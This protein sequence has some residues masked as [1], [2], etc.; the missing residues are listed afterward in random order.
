VDRGAG[1]DVLEGQRVAH[2]DVGLRAGGDGRSDLQSNRLQD[3]ALFAIR[4]VDEGNA[5]RAVGIILDGRNLARNPE[6][7]A[8]EIDQAQLLLVTA[9]MVTDRQIARIAASAGT[10]LDRQKRLVRLGRRQVVI[11]QRSLEAQGRR[12]RSVCL[13]SHRLCPKRAFSC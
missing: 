9:A 8:L 13:N 6:L 1:G 10:L 4:I 5:R 11:D 12:D 2:Q 3:V 7:V